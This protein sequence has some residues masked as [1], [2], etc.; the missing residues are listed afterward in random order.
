M[1]EH[2]LWT[3]F[4]KMIVSGDTDIEH[5][6]NVPSITVGIIPSTVIS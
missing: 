5:K 3:T 6:Y 4:S 1:I 2:Y